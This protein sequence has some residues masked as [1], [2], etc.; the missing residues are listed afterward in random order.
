[1]SVT[2]AIIEQINAHA[3]ARNYKPDPVPPEWLEAIVAAGQ[4]AS[5]SSNLQAYSVIAVTNQEAR[6]TLAHLCGDQAHIAQ[7]PLFLAFCA[8]LSRLNHAAELRHHPFA[9]QPT[10]HFVIA[11][12]DAAL[13]A[14]NAA[15]TAESLGLGVCYIG[16]LRNHP[17]EVARL[18]HLP[19]LMFPLVGMTL[20]FPAQ[21]GRIRPR[22]Q[23]K[24][25][26][27]H[28]VYSDKNQDAALQEYD[29]AMI[30]TGIYENRQ[31]AVPGHPEKME[32][33]GW[34]EHS[35]RRMSR[36]SR[37]NLRA[38]LQE[39]GFGME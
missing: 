34:T 37:P 25:V 1:M 7:A 6:D 23:L 12:V 9:S 21:A 19:P 35:A 10:E 28:E 32:R 4:R 38:Q 11:A 27:H 14:Q 15:L 18:L 33:Y 24:G 16:S 31:V 5:T 3:S 22:L 8:D 30:A 39:M 26:L 13:M 29:E 17:P 20:G 2:N 36:Q